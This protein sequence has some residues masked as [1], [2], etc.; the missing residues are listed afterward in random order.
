MAKKKPKHLP[1]SSP[2]TRPIAEQWGAQHAGVRRSDHQLH[3]LDLMD[4]EDLDDYR[5]QFPEAAEALA[6][7]DELEAEMDRRLTNR[8]GELTVEQLEQKAPERP[9]LA[10]VV[11]SR[12]GASDVVARGEFLRYEPIR[13]L[14]GTQVIVDMTGVGDADLYV[15]FNQAP[16]RQAA[17]CRPFLDG[18]DER[19]VLDVPANA[20]TAHI[21]VDG[22]T[23]AAFDFTVEWTEPTP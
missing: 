4:D 21:A 20:T 12:C 10:V 7:Y 9:I 13:V 1:K 19:C 17:N 18:S 8:L 23:A 22:F 5:R 2:C 3:R 6:T 14:P 15:R 16:T 11:C